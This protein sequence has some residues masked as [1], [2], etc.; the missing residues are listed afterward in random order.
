[1]FKFSFIYII[2]YT[3]IY[4]LYWCGCVCV[5]ACMHCMYTESSQVLGKD[6]N[7]EF[8]YPALKDIF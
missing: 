4:I 5:C 2:Y 8:I 7:T 1:M 3:H 6:S